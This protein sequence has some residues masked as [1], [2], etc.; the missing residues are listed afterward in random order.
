MCE[1]V[2][3]RNDVFRVSSIRPEGIEVLH[4]SVPTGFVYQ[5]CES[6]RGRYHSCESG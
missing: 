4:F 3:C 1:L 2:I 6:T 5:V